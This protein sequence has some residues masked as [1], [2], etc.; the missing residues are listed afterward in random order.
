MYAVLGY[1]WEG[2]RG[3][4]SPHWAMVSVG[5]AGWKKNPKS[6]TR[7]VPL[8]VSSRDHKKKNKKRKRNTE[9]K[10]KEKKEYYKKIKKKKSEHRKTLT[11]KKR[12]NT[13]PADLEAMATIVQGIYVP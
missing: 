7:D 13:Q 8:V 3:Q 1:S 9:T 5:L 11:Q 12:E 2:V 4:Q 6:W 10:K